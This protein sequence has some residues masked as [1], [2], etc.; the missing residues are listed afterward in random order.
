MIFLREIEEVNFSQ[1]YKKLENA[2]PYEERRDFQDYEIYF[3]NKHFKPFEIVDSTKAVGLVNLWL[4]ESYIYI[5]HLLIDPELRSGGYGTKAIEL[6]KK[7]YKKPIILEAEA[8]ETEIQIKRIR[9]YEKSGFKINPYSY[10]QPSFH[11]GEPVP[12][13]LLSYPELLTQ[14]QYDLFIKE[15]REN[16][17]FNC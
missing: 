10:L 9:F 16:V 8:P 2:F 13:K 3:K 7:L 17:Y 12:L 6:V 4:F 11:N 1:I 5:E 14:D 15:T